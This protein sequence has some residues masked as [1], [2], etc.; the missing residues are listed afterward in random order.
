MTI[1]EHFARQRK[2]YRITAILSAVLWVLGLA[3]VLK[4]DKA[5]MESE[6]STTVFIGKVIFS[7]AYPAWFA[8]ILIPV[9]KIKCPVCKKRMGAIRKKWNHCPFCGVNMDSEMKTT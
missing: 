5:S 4:L 8:A 1:R 3:I 2:P 7:C 9:F 6:L